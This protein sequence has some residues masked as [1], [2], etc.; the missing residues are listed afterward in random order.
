MCRRAL[1][2]CRRASSRLSGCRAA[3]ISVSRRSAPGA[4]DVAFVE[5][6]IG[7][8]CRIN[9]PADMAIWRKWGDDPWTGGPKSVGRLHGG[10]HRGALALRQPPAQAPRG[11]AEGHV[12]DGG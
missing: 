10:L 9:L 3:G 4:D 6:A 12:G 2:T 5:V 7:T 11:A 8:S 1:R